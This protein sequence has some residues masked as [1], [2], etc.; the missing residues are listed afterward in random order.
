MRIAVPDHDD[1]VELRC[2]GGQW[3]V[4]NGE[5][6]QIKFAMAAEPWGSCPWLDGGIASVRPP[7]PLRMN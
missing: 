7:L 6:V 5:P 3:F 2:H 1:A 4:E